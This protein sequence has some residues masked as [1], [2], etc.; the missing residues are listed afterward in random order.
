MASTVHGGVSGYFGL[1]SFKEMCLESSSL[2]N[3]SNRKLRA[4]TAAIA[5]HHIL[6]DF[7]HFSRRAKAHHAAVCIAFGGLVSPLQWSKGRGEHEPWLMCATHEK[8]SMKMRDP[9]VNSKMG[10]ILRSI[11]FA[12]AGMREQRQDRGVARE[13]SFTPPHSLK[14]RTAELL[15]I[16]Q[17]LKS[18]ICLLWRTASKN[19]HPPDLCRIVARLRDRSRME[20][21]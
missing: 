10:L 17:H 9:G 18:K 3:D 4:L 15:D 7:N 6:A 21:D 13:R 5:L 12:G 11:K 1:G 16:V 20:S 14:N 2:Q 8:G 19:P